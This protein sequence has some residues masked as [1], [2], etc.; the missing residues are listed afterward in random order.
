MNWQ[1]IVTKSDKAWG[2]VMRKQGPDGA[3]IY[4]VDVESV[5]PL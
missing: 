4:I 1:I 5:K 2:S 3:E